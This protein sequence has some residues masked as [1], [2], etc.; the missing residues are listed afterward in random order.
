MTHRRLEN[1]DRQL[2]QSR[3]GLVQSV[4]YSVDYPEEDDLSL[5]QAGHTYFDSLIARLPFVRERLR[6]LGEC[7]NSFSFLVARPSAKSV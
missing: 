6:F 5:S 3:F 7:V 1:E 2:G 4:A